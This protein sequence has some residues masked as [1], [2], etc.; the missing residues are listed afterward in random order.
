MDSDTDKCQCVILRVAQ[1]LNRRVIK[2][3]YL[4]SAIY[5]LIAIALAVGIYVWLMRM[6]R[7]M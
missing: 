5:F 1:I 7:V 6:P 4:K 2:T 3:P